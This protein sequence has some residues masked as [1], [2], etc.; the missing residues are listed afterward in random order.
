MAKEFTGAIMK[1]LEID[2]EDVFTDPKSF[3]Q[4]VLDA[5][6]VL[7]Q[8][9]NTD[10]SVSAVGQ[11]IKRRS[12]NTELGHD[13]KT[14]IK[15]ILEQ[16]EEIPLEELSVLIDKMSKV[17]TELKAI[18]QDRTVY[19]ATRNNASLH[20]K[21]VAHILYVNLRNAYESYRK[22]I[23]A[24]NPDMLLPVMPAKSGNY[25]GNT[26]MRIRMFTLAEYPD[27]HF[28][29]HRSVANLLGLQGRFNNLG[30]FLDWIESDENRDENG[31]VLVEVREVVQ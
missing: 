28:Y 23:K 26:P 15:E 25:G 18:L 29:S 21:R 27:D 19:E 14:Y 3:A 12:V 7:E 6:K 2:T 4:R 13:M 24:F 17:Q 31:D 8:T 30:D 10:T 5:G 20:D 1:D 16:A 22:M 11:A 9:L